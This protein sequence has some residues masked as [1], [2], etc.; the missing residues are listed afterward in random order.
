MSFT[1]HYLL[2]PSLLYAPPGQEEGLK[3][4]EN[5]TLW[6][7]TLLLFLLYNFQALRLPQFI[8]ST[9]QLWS[10]SHPLLP[11]LDLHLSRMS[12]PSPYL[13]LVI[14]VKSFMLKLLTL[15]SPLACSPLVSLFLTHILLTSFPWPPELCKVTARLSSTHLLGLA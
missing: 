9:P 1:W 11:S 3:G 15:L 13:I 4:K 8:I 2:G 5:S 14:I 6:E 10:E 12:Q 7:D